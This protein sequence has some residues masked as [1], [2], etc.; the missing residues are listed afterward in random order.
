MK[1]GIMRGM[2]LGAVVG[3]SALTILG[4]VDVRTRKT[5]K[6]FMVGAM[7]QASDQAEKIMK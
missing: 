7:Q 1:K 6:K 2:A 5:V 3:V 4:A